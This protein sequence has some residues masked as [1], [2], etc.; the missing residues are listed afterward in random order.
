MPMSASCVVNRADLLALLEELRQALPDSLAEARE[1]IGGREQM[2][3][4]ARQ[5][6]QRIIEAAHAERGSLISDTQ[7]ARESRAGRPDPGGG[8]PRGRGDPRRGGR[9]RRLKLA[10]FEVVLTKTIGSV[11]RGR[12]SS[13][14]GAPAWTPTGTP[15]RTRPSTATTRRPWSSAPTRMWTPS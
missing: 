4:Q 2:V 1:L 5:E 12:E 10:N 14:A 11:D 7:V 15:T 3:E 6:A 9:L 13:S 8:P